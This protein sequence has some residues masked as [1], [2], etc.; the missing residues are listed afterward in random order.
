MKIPT[1][2]PQ[3][4]DSYL[5]VHP[6]AKE[7]RYH[8]FLFYDICVELFEGSSATGEDAFTPTFDHNKSIFDLVRSPV[9]SYS[10]TGDS[11]GIVE[12]TRT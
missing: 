2:A 11:T 5:K 9:H 1:A 12:T 4:W 6:G 3:V 8:T 7:F 10:P